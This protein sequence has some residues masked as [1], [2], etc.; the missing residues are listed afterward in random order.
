MFKY[1]VTKGLQLKLAEWFMASD[2]CQNVSL[3]AL[4]VVIRELNTAIV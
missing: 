2:S 4:G 1:A 3:R